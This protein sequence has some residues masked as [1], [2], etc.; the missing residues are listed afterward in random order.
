V[1]RITA[2]NFRKSRA[3]VTID[4]LIE[5]LNIVVEPNEA[6]KSTLLEAIRAYFFVPHRSGNQL[7]S[8]YQPFGGKSGRMP[9]AAHNAPT[10]RL[11]CR[12]FYDGHTDEIFHR[13]P[14]VS[15]TALAPRSVFPRRPIAFHAAPYYHSC[16]V[17]AVVIQGAGA[18]RNR[19]AP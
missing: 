15:A 13:R 6:G 19:S 16:T 8:S 18:Y 17:A 5:G 10:S 1:R 12:R 3:P 14:G 4:G 2:N 11:E 7:A 9:G